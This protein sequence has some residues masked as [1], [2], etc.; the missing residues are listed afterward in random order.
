M[1]VDPNSRVERLS[2]LLE[3]SSLLNSQLELDPLMQTVVDAARQFCQARLGGLLLL[4]EDDPTQFSDLWVSGWAVPPRHYPTGEGLYNLPLKT[5]K[6]VRVDHA[7]DHPASVGTP[8]GHPPI[9]PFL[10]VPLMIKGR[11]V[12]TLFVANFPGGRTFTAEDEELLV[13]FAAHAAVATHNARLYRKVEELATLRE[14]ERLAMDLHDSLAQIFFSIGMELER[15]QDAVNESGRER[16]QYLLSLVARGTAKVRGA[17]SELYERG[18]IPGDAN[19]YRR[20]AALVD[21]FRNEYKMQIG[22]VVTG[23]VH[24]VPSSYHEVFCRALREALVNVHKHARADMA[25][26]NL[27]VEQDCVRLIVQDNGVGLAPGALEGAPDVR[28]FGLVAI[29][30]QLER[31]GGT[32][33]VANGDDGG[34]I[35]RI[36]A[37]LHEADSAEGAMHAADPGPHR[38]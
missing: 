21:E 26:V 31:L 13:A 2:S 14:R 1:P 10:G 16:L 9:G 8:N 4:A 29:R 20:C 33:E 18:S 30:R 12:G 23:N 28:R 15:L 3:L 36:W 22:L 35:V 32:L 24:R 25:V 37:P 7:P 27:A 17:I 19:L 38:G 11:V 5:G 6:P 34:C